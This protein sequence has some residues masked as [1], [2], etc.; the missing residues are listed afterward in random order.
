[1]HWWAIMTSTLLIAEN[2]LINCTCLAY[3]TSSCKKVGALHEYCNK[4][5]KWING[6]I[7]Y[8][9]VM[10]AV[11]INSLSTHDIA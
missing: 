1:M 9:D 2:C 5:Y 8:N 6:E 10:T 4:F 3:V 7:K 11:N